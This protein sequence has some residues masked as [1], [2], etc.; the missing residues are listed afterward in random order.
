MSKLAHSSDETMEQIERAARDRPDEP[1][2]KVRFF[3]ID[4]VHAVCVGG[5]WDGWLMRKH[6]DGQWVTVRKLEESAP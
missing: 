6:S 1:K 2:D 3:R 4:Y 5:R